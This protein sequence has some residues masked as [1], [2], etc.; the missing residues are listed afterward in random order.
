MKIRFHYSNKDIAIL[1]SLAGMWALSEINLGLFLRVLKIPFSGALLTSFGLIILFLARDAVPQRG[2]LIL[3]GFLTSY[4]KLIFLGALAFFPIIAILIESLIVEISL[5]SRQINRANTM[6]AGVFAMLW[7][8]IHPFFTQGLLSGW[9]I[10]RVYDIFFKR[11]AA[12]FGISSSSI[13][14][15]FALVVFIHFLLGILASVVGWR[16]TRQIYFLFPT[17][18]SRERYQHL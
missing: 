17:Q 2:T 7:S 13:V 11:S 8:L 14:L 1:S 15:I 16:L 3:M 6:L 4:L 9:G 12:I 5:S 10:N 18:F